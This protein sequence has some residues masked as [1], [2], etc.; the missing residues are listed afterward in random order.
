MTGRLYDQRR[1]K[2]VRARQLAREPLCRAC[3]AMGEVT[4]AEHVDHIVAIADGGAPFDPG[5][6]Q[7]LCPSHHSLKTKAVDEA[8]HD[9]DA[10]SHRGA[11]SDGSPR[12]P[13]HPWYSGPPD[14][15]GRSIAVAEGATTDAG[16]ILELVR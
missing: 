15:E 2:R 11:F 13:S 5:N 7:S 16:S 14:P 4:A 8:G 10:W 3:R 12:D 6:L 9:A 1:W